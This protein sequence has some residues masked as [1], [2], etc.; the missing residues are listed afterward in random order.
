MTTSLP[1]AKRDVLKHRAMIALMLLAAFAGC[2]TDENL[3]P[4]VPVKG[5]V[6][7]QGKPV[8]DAVVMFFPADDVVGNPGIAKTEADGA[9]QLTTYETGDGAV[10]GKHTVT[11][12][13]FNAPISLPGKYGSR[14]TTPLTFIVESNQENH[15]EIVLEK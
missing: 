7:Y 14:E 3:P 5:K 1:A 4:T 2:G 15:F 13:L 6:I 12:Q 10:P 9:Y 8:K 11:V